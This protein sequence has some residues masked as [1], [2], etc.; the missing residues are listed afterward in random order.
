[1]QRKGGDGDK[2]SGKEEMMMKAKPMLRTTETKY[3][4]P[5]CLTGTEAL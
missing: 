1:M 3:A 2:C 4:I 5:D